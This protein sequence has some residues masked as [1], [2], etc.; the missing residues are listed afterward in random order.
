MN[1]DRPVRAPGV[2]DLAAPIARRKLHEAVEERL[3]ARIQ[4]GEFADG[5]ALPSERELMAQYGVGRPAVREALQALAHAGIVEIAHG[6]R[7]RV[8]ALSADTLIDRLGLGARHWLRVAPESLAQLK[9]ARVLIEGGL[10][11][12][13]AANADAAALGRLRALLEQQRRSLPEIEAFLQA[14]M[15]F[16]REIARIAGNPIFPPMV[17]AFFAW[18]GEY[19]RPMVHAAGVEPLTLVEHDRILQAIARR[20]A[21]AAQAAMIE[22]LSR[23]NALYR[24]SDPG[25]D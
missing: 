13:A 6:E 11:A 4:Q 16:H 22:H 21:P 2:G 20:D 24:Q 1:P 17:E 8:R 9:D 23:A 14:D 10:A 19:H 18:A 5:Q 25:V 12:R 7:A 3:L 15:A